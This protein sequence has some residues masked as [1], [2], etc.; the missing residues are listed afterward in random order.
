MAS[1]NSIQV[2]R[3][4]R[5]DSWRRIGHPGNSRSQ[6]GAPCRQETAQVRRNFPP[7]DRSPC[8]P[9][10]DLGIYRSR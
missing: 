6:C 1:E 2:I 9:E 4:Q 10:R 8:R 7:D 3:P 5:R